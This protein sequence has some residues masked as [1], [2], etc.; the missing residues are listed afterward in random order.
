[1]ESNANKGELA[2][3]ENENFG[4]VRWIMRDGEPWFVA[5]DIAEN[6]GYT[7]PSRSIQDHCNYAE[8]FK[9]TESVG[10]D[11]PARGL[12]IIPESDV[13]ALIFRSNLPKAIEFRKWVCEEVLPSIRKT[14]K[15]A[16]PTADN[17]GV[18]ERLRLANKMLDTAD[19]S[20]TMRLLVMGDIIQKTTGFNA[21]EACHMNLPRA[22][23][24]PILTP[25]EIAAVLGPDF[26][27]IGIRMVL[28]EMGLQEYRQREWQ[29]TKEGEKYG[30][31]Y[32]PVYNRRKNTWSDY[33]IRWRPIIIDKIRMHLGLIFREYDT[34]YNL[35]GDFSL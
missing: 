22:S 28:G 25:K 24:E 31:D 20:K 29:L 1:M 33:N 19:V 11:I 8:L 4:K 10:L 35:L 6:L 3:F 27:E 30:M 13:Y 16:M 26:G 12:L 18:D 17:I 2:I 5:L 9:S 32:P 34:E 15:Y 23:G 7:N 21:I 14:G